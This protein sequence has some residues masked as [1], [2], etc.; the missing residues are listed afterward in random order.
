MIKLSKLL[1]ILSLS[2]SGC[3]EYVK[4]P[5]WVCPAP[6]M[7]QEAP[8]K[9]DSI[10]DSSTTDECLKAV[11]SDV[12]YLRGLNAQYKVLLEGYKSKEMQIQLDR[13]VQ[14]R[15]SSGVR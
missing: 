14:G 2:L 6:V 15:Y 3:V 11:I 7:P 1:I 8:L 9:V 13:L 4:V 10:T 12:T 5:V